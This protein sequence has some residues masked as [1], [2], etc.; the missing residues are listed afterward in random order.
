MVVK[1]YH[2]YTDFPPNVRLLHRLMSFLLINHPFIVIYFCSK[3]NRVN[4]SLH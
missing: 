3:K 4:I 2:A 1:L